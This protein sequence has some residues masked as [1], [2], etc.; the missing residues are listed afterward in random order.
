MPTTFSLRASLALAGLALTAMS[1]AALTQFELV[2][3]NPTRS[4]P[5]GIYIRVD[6]PVERGVVVTIPVHASRLE[7]V[8]EG[9]VKAA[10]DRFLKR[11]ASDTVV[12]P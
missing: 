6:Q 3:Y 8:R 4:L 12:L 1:V 7:Y 10:G 5:Q 11:L 9:H 2:L